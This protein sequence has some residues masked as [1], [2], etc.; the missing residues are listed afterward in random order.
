M[1]V[2]L[3]EAEWA[4]LLRCINEGEVVPVVGPGAVTFGRADQLLYTWLA[5]RL[6][7]ELDPSLEFEKPPQ[8]ATANRW[9]PARASE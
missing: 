8:R 5:Q 3:N 7:A 6:P 4:G 9:C 2:E 1:S